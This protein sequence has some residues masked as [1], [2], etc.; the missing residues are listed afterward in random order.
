MVPRV[1][2]KLFHWPQSPVWQVADWV[3]FSSKKEVSWGIL[4]QQKKRG[5]TTFVISFNLH[6]TIQGWVELKNQEAMNRLWNTETTWDVISRLYCVASAPHIFKSH[7]PKCPQLRSFKWLN[8]YIV[9]IWT[10][11]IFSMKLIC[12]KNEKRQAIQKGLAL[13][14]K[15]FL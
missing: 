13:I 15:I 7:T 9:T 5:I 6:V 14:F 10:I 8:V 4:R 11:R 12:T 1:L 2:P 3:V